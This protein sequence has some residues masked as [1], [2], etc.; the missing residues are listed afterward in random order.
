VKRMEKPELELILLADGDVISTSECLSNTAIPDGPP[1]PVCAPVTA[2]PDGPP[3]PVCESNNGMPDG[4]PEDSS[5]PNECSAQFR[6][7]D[8]LHFG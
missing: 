1:A 7:V 6:C 3:A 5:C 8:C 2:V 4:F